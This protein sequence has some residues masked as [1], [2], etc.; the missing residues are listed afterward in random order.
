MISADTFDDITE[1]QSSHDW[2]IIGLANIFEKILGLE[3]MSKVSYKP[4]KNDSDS[5]EGQTSEAYILN[6]INLFVFELFMLNI[7]Y[8]RNR[9]KYQLQLLIC[10]F[11]IE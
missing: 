4:R 3:R 10:D 9:L 2:T 11:L 7:I 8:E 1:D 6:L 5:N